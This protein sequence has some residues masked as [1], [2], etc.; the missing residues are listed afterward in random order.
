MSAISRF[1]ADYRGDEVAVIT[2]YAR[3]GLSCCFVGSAGVG[4]SNLLRYLQTNYT[5]LP[6]AGEALRLRF[7]TV[8]CNEW[9]GAPAR[10]WQMLRTECE[11][12]FGMTPK[13]IPLAE[14]SER[15][16]Q[17]T[18]NLLREVCSQPNQRI[19]IILDDCDILLRQGPKSILGQLRTLRDLNKDQLSYLLLCKRLPHLL[20]RD[21]YLREENKFYEL[22]DARIYTLRPYNHSDGMQMLRFLNANDTR[23]VSNA[24][25]KAIFYLAG[26]HA[27]LLR[28]L[29][30]IYSTQP[31]AGREPIPALLSH[32]DIQNACDRLFRPLHDHEK[33]VL[34][35]LALSRPLTPTDQPSVDLLHKRGLL[36]E[37]GNQIFSP[38]F[39]AY[40]RALPPA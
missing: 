27:N 34:K 37:P 12:A 17:I 19:V 30:E 26:G 9:D 40:V 25:L 33:T 31:P 5:T 28:L 32:N 2:D 20:G 35:A 10:L 6:D 11:S 18:R 1:P 13:V 15:D 38:V 36:I 24:T 8:A 29:R 39:A 3:R 23:P 16:Y 21:L 14:Q 7:V 22:F 4:K